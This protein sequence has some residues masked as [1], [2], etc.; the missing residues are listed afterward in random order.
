LTKRLRLVRDLLLVIL[1]RC[2]GFVLMDSMASFRDCRAPPSY[3][4]EEEVEGE[5]S[6][7]SGDDLKKSRIDFGVSLVVEALVADCMRD[8]KE[9]PF[10]GPG[11]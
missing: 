3:R 9:V 1:G 7:G 10:S 2:R 5:E 8:M 6:L 4:E 11:L